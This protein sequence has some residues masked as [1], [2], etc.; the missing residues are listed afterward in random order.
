MKR[1]T[2]L[3][4]EGKSNLSSIAGSYLVFCRAN[5]RWRSLGKKEPFRIEVAGLS[6]EINLEHGLFSIHPNRSVGEIKKTDLVIIPALIP[7]YPR[8]IK[9]N[10]G[11]LSWIREQY[12]QGAEIASLCSGAFLLASTGLVDGRKCS[13]HWIAAEEFRRM[14]PDV[15]VADG[16]VITDEYGI[17]TNGGA[18]SFLNLLLYL[19]EKYYDRETAIFCS[20]VFQIDIGRNSQS[21]YTMFSGQKKHNDGLVQEAQLFFENHF[22]E[23][24]SMENL[25]GRL[26]AGR[27]N[28]DRRFIKATGNTPAEYLQRTRVEAAKRSLETSRKTINEVMYET[29]YSDTKTFREVFKK[30]TGLSPL[31]YR[32]KYNKETEVMA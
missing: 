17:Y 19:V 16:Q 4:P 15:T 31:E 30:I 1:L 7:P 3:I 28:F 32:N 20:K 27:R 6:P 13:T 26:A 11:L 2:I 25:A 29:G 5:E 12:K 9:Q 23:K 21:P 18:F 10:T 24:I 14:F 8:S 22:D